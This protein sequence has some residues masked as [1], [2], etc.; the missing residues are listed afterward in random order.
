MT[1]SLSGTLP[2]DGHWVKI[3][4]GWGSFSVSYAVSVTSPGEFACYIGLWPFRWSSG[5][6]VTPDVGANVVTHQV[7]VY[8]D[9]WLRTTSR[10]TSTYTL[11]P[12]GPAS[13]APGSFN[14]MR[15]MIG[16]KRG[17]A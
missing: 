14:V 8:G 7:A 13:S 15:S 12:I 17:A 5:V 4:Y 9:V 3:L 1:G 2:N 6:L 16:T 11:Q 10:R